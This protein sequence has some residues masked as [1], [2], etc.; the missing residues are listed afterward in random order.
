[1]HEGIYVA[2]VWAIM[3]RRTI[4]YVDASAAFN[5][6][7]S[8]PRMESSA[9]KYRLALVYGHFMYVVVSATVAVP[10]ASR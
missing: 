7:S 8:A 9:N 1:M 2:D 10:V 5:K 3:L 4:S 6:Y